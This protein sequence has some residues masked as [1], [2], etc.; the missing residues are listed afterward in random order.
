VPD[1][2][3]LSLVTFKPIDSA[4]VGLEFFRTLETANAVFTPEAIDAEGMRSAT[5]PLSDSQKARFW[6]RSNLAMKREAPFRSYAILSI[7]KDDLRKAGGSFFSL[8][9]DISYFSPSTKL[10]EAVD[11]GNGLYKVLEPC[12]GYIHLPWMPGL[13]GVAYPTK[14]LP[15]WGWA[16]WLGPEYGELVRVPMIEGLTTVSMFD[17][18]RLFL[19][20]RPDDVRVPNAK[21]ISI[22]S[23]IVQSLPS[24]IFQPFFPSEPFDLS[25]SGGSEQAES[26]RLVSEI[27]KTIREGRR[28]VRLPTFRFRNSS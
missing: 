8:H 6:E 1:H 2:F 12:Y 22:H 27:S 25:Q 5:Y 13:T 18:G 23:K 11:L 20:P 7:A 15:G 3:S 14:G 24:E 10:G 9:T 21:C 17:N 28:T 4:G 16:T 19:L 26:R